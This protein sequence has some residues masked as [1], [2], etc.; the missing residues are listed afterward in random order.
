M[1]RPEGSVTEATQW[2]Q[3]MEFDKGHSGVHSKVLVLSSWYT[4]DEIHKL[5][6][7][8]SQPTIPKTGFGCRSTIC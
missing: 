5:V 6:K 8:S 1:A 7:H 2:K 3:T 4:S